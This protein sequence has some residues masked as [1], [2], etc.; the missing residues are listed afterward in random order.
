MSVMGF[1]GYAGGFKNLKKVQ[2]SEKS[3]ESCRDG[4]NISPLI[5]SFYKINTYCRS[6]HNII[7][8]LESLENV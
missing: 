3:E 7:F 1:L 2:Y 8:F 6:H 4:L 5:L